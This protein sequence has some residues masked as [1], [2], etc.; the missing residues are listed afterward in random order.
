MFLCSFYSCDFRW[1]C[2]KQVTEEPFLSPHFVLNHMAL[3][4]CST[5]FCLSSSSK[6]IEAAAVRIKCETKLPSH[7]GHTTWQVLLGRECVNTIESSHTNSHHKFSY[8]II[9]YRKC[10]KRVNQKPEIW[11]RTKL[12]RRK[13]TVTPGL[14]RQNLKSSDCSLNSK[15]V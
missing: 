5:S 10:E 7:T 15:C 9:F 4:Q 2:V 6:L 11:E 13:D 8:E 14:F 3:A 1:Q 12:K